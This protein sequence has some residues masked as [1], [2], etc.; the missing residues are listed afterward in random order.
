MGL[1]GGVGKWEELDKKIDF[2]NYKNSDNSQLLV[3]KIELIFKAIVLRVD[4]QENNLSFSFKKPRFRH[5]IGSSHG[6]EKNHSSRT[7]RP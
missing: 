3:S 4:F 2:S 1:T 5:S 7:V 6:V